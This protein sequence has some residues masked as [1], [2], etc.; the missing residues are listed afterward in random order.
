MLVLAF[1]LGLAINSTAQEVVKYPLALKS[2]EKLDDWLKKM[3]ENKKYRQF[4]QDYILPVE[5]VAKE[6]RNFRFRSDI[7]AS[8][9]NDY[10][11]MTDNLRKL[12]TKGYQEWVYNELGSK[13][14]ELQGIINEISNEAVSI[15]KENY[16]NCITRSENGGQDC[17]QKK[18]VGDEGAYTYRLTWNKLEVFSRAPVLF[19]PFRNNYSVDGWGVELWEN[20]PFGG[21]KIYSFEFYGLSD[22][23]LFPENP[24]Y[25]MVKGW[26]SSGKG[27][28]I[29]VLWGSHFG[30]G[31]IK[32][33]LKPYAVF[34][35]GFWVRHEALRFQ[36]LENRDHYHFG[37]NIM[38]GPGVDLFLTK[39]LVFS[40]RVEMQL[41]LVMDFQFR[42]K[43]GL[44]WVVF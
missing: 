41:N 12:A 34:G 13:F 22:N 36:P 1:V 33:R 15:N 2:V 3:E 4:S 38:A 31:I 42:Y 19:A 32:G 39:N 37:L 11:Y 44:S 6:L 14:L 43:T 18:G 24:E 10:F 29:N 40:S 20:R 21:F 5:R 28:S 7:D 30:K 16:N 8:W 25:N 17:K 23:G 35:P 9:N 26:V 27:A